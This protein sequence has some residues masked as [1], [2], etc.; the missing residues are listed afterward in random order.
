MTATP[1]N[2]RKNVITM[3]SEPLSLVGEELQ[4]GQKAPDF[5]LVATDLSEKSLAD[6]EGKVKILAVV[7]SLDTSVCD[8]ETR[9]FN[10]KA[11]SLSDDIVVLTVSC[12]LPFAQKR[13]CGAAGVD[14]VECL[15]DYKTNEFGKDYGLLVDGLAVLCRAVLVLDKDNKVVYQQ[16]VPEIA[17]EPDYDAAL[18]AAKAAV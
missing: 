4:V 15:S 7:P 14:H 2:I 3:K 18:A 8:T 17:S 10:E 1:T 6:Y 9:T 5:K 11:G 16:I 13:W 12:D